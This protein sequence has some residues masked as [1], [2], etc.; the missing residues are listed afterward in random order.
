MEL[1]PN[2]LGG[3][4]SHQHHQRFGLERMVVDL[5]KPWAALTE[6]EVGKKEP[7]FF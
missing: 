7:C 1:P 5:Q 3:F 2:P 6:S 4:F